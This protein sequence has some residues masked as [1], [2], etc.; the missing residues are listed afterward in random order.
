MRWP[1]KCDCRTDYQEHERLSPH[2]GRN[3]RRRLVEF[4]RSCVA[5]TRESLGGRRCS[6]G[7][8]SWKGT[9][10]GAGLVPQA[11]PVARYQTFTSRRNGERGT[12]AFCK[13]GINEHELGTDRS[14]R[15]LSASTDMTDVSGGG[16]HAA[17]TPCWGLFAIGLP[18]H[19]L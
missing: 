1:S 17:G 12:S 4:M 6:L 7:L 18:Q 13:L 10:D 15:L 16:F 3:L 9:L 2:P 14:E 11:R 5:C 19:R 8:E